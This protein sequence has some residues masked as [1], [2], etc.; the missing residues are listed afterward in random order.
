MQ[1]LPSTNAAPNFTFFKNIY[2]QISLCLIHV[3]FRD[4]GQTKTLDGSAGE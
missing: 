4:C 1:N 3:Y 2:I